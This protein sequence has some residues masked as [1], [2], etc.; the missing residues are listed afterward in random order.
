MYNYKETRAPNPWLMCSVIRPTLPKP[1]QGAPASLK[2]HTAEPAISQSSP[3]AQVRRQREAVLR[4]PRGINPSVL[5]GTDN[6]VPI[7]ALSQDFCC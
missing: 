4:G 2:L 1:W 6:V 7:L 3:P 5:P